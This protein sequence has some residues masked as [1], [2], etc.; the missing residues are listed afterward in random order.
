MTKQDVLERQDAQRALDHSDIMRLVREA[1][2]GGFQARERSPVHTD[3]A[4]FVS[5]RLEEIA[6]TPEFADAPMPA[7]QVEEPMQ[8]VAEPEPV[9]APSPE[10]EAIR[11]EAFEAGKNEGITQGLAQGRAEGRIQGEAEA[12]RMIQEARA[13][14]ERATTN[15]STLTTGDI[16]TLADTVTSAINALASQR[17]GTVIDEMPENFMNRVEQLADRV[18]QGVRQVTIRLNAN[19]LNVIEPFLQGSELLSENRIVADSRL[20]R[21]DVDV[22]SGAITLSDILNISQPVAAE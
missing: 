12:N 4:G 1:G 6:P 15:L 10:L 14:F 7:P 22:R 19:D 11:A 20:G 3:G 5:R 9:A 2:K 17:A 18:A 21:G 8:P 16:R 13:T